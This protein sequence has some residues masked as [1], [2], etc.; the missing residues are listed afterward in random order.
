MHK[1][2]SKYA[3]L[4]ETNRL[5]KAKI[6]IIG[7][8]GGIATGKTTVGKILREL[9]FYVIDA[10]KLVKDIY[11]DPLTIK[12]I[13]KIAPEAVSE[14]KII[15]FPKLREVFFSDQEVKKTVENFIYKALPNEF[16]KGIIQAQNNNH[17]LIFYEVPLLF[18]KSLQNQL[19]LSVCVY[20]PQGAQIERLA[21]RDKNSDI[22]ID[23]ILKS[24]IDIETKKEL[25]DFVIENNL[26]PKELRSNIQSFIKLITE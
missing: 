9:G 19:D 20:A 21:T 23:K 24:Q 2:K 12:F 18:E 16:S 4:D 26:G 25:A 3:I 5:Y 10:D 7:L 14:L 11:S 13:Q 15:N 6:P 8:T 1:L 22:L 17:K